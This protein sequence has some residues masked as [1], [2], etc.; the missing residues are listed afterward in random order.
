MISSPFS[1]SGRIRR[2]EYWFFKIFIFAVF[3]CLMAGVAH[4]IINVLFFYILFVPI[5][6]I[7]LAQNTKRCHDRG[8]SVFFQFIPFYNLILLFGNSDF[9]QNQFGPNAKDAGNNDYNHQFGKTALELSEYEK[10][11]KNGF[12]FRR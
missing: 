10:S 7:N 1:F 2:S 3:L 5:L 4:R 8:N 9:G 11:Y 6:W 12:D